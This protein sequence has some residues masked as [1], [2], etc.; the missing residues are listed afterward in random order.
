[1]TANGSR[2]QCMRD[3][4]RFRRESGIRDARPYGAIGSLA[5]S[6]GSELRLQRKKEKGAKVENEREIVQRRF[7]RCCGEKGND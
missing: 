2:Q 6:L 3:C 7:Y 4:V 5:K 1:M